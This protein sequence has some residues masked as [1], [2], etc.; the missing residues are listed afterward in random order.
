MPWA[1][2][3]TPAPFCPTASWRVDSQPRANPCPIAWAD[4]LTSLFLTAE[5]TEHGPNRS[6]FCSRTLPISLSFEWTLSHVAGARLSHYCQVLLTLFSESHELVNISCTSLAAS[7]MGTQLLITAVCLFRQAF[8]SRR[9]GVPP[10]FLELF[11]QPRFV[12]RATLEVLSANP[13]ARCN[14]LP[15]QAPQKNT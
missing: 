7:P 4:C 5:S 11:L 10:L 1:C 13:K 12:C 14:R 6:P 2:K 3:R 15:I 9:A 8:P